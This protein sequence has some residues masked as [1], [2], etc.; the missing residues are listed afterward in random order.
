[1]K[2]FCLAVAAI[3]ALAPLAAEM[4][5]Q[6]FHVDMEKQ[7]GEWVCTRSEVRDNGRYYEVWNR[8]DLPEGS[9]LEQVFIV[10]SPTSKGHKVSMNKLMR[11][12]LFPVKYMP[13]TRT[14]VHRETAN[15][16]V[17]A[18]HTPNGH[19]SIV[20]LLVHPEVYHSITY[21]HKGEK[22]ADEETQRRVNFLDTLKLTFSQ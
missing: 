19:Q 22:L 6:H 15:E 20:R 1:M 21:L 2:K 18:W 3:F 9:E 5:P 16:A 17:F 11:K 4:L 10:S 7:E 13:G 12:S 8:A 14:Q